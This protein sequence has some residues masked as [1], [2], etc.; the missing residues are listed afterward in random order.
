[1][2]SDGPFYMVKRF[3]IYSPQDGKYVGPNAAGQP[4]AI[5]DDRGRAELYREEEI[6]RVA[7]QALGASP[8]YRRQE[9]TLSEYMSWRGR[10]GGKAMSPK[11]LRT[12][13]RIAKRKRPG[14][15]KATV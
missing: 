6:D 7:A 2:E 5:V 3:F 13:K 4:S 10:Q 12:L 8:V 9:P 14:R 1:M 15:K 11:K